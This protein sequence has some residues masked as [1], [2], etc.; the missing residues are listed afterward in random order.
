[1]Y[2][3]ISPLD[4]RYFN[5][6]TEIAEECNEC[7]IM[8]AKIVAEIEYLLFF[9]KTYKSIELSEIEA[10]DL[11]SLY[12]EFSQAD[13]EEINKIERYDTHHDI[14]AIEY[15]IRS[16][17]TG[18]D[19][20]SNEVIDSVH[21]GITSQDIVSLGTYFVIIN[22]VRLIEDKLNLL[23]M[24]FNKLSEDNADVKFLARTHG[25]SAIATTVDREV[26]RYCHF[27]QNDY[28]KKITLGVKFGG[29]VGSLTSL[30]QEYP[31]HDVETEFNNFIASLSEDI[32]NLTLYRSQHTS[33]SDHWDSLVDVMHSLEK[34]TSGMINIC[35]DFWMYHSYGY[36]ITNVDKGYCGS[37]TMPQKVNPI[38]FENAEGC[39]EK[40]EADF[41]FL[42]R[43]LHKSRLQ[44]DLSDSVVIRMIYETFSWMYLGI[45]S[46]IDG[47]DNIRF[48][49]TV[50][51]EELENNY[52]ILAEFVQLTL[53]KYNTE[54]EDV[55]AL[56]KDKFRGLRTCAKKQYLDIIDSLEIEDDYVYNLLKDMEPKD[57]C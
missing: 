39:F 51:D 15:W 22:C 57:Y 23:K 48:D 16:K 53:K 28:S 9:L 50:C 8:Q 3:I 47:I 11:R 5:K 45:T 55:Y 12:L 38:K 44:R 32:P 31:D 27:L 30:K 10:N 13:F 18:M 14:K 20:F 54:N 37:S 25:Q 49:K 36:I 21:Y 26:G 42:C 43:K 2:N 41:Q 46:L 29:A 52:Q 33:Q 40:V 1:M 19:Y 6:I 7:K 35:R 34:T 24:K 17:I 56:V 4:G